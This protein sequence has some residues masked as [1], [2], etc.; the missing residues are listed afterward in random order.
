MNNLNPTQTKPGTE[1]SLLPEFTR[2]GF[3][4]K[5]IYECTWAQFADRYGTNDRRRQLL[6]NIQFLL[7]QARR[8]M[9]NVD[10]YV[11]GSFVTSK[12]QPGDFDMTWEISGEQVGQL[13]KSAEILVNRQVQKE[14][15]G[16]QLMVTYPNSPNGGVLGWLQQN[17]GRPVGVVKVNVGTLPPSA[18]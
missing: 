9:G 6:R 13:Y 18:Q 17:R 16:G 10:I 5:G 7:E 15:L 8:Q 2:D 12:E 1:L 4:P 11:G 14:K 3:L